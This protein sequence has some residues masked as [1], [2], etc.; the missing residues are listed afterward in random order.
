MPLSEHLDRL[1]AFEPT[2]LPV[3]TL[4]LNTQPDQHGRANFEPFVRKELQA[5]GQTFPLRSPERE[6]FEQDAG[7]IRRYLRDE[8]RPSTNGVAI[9]ACAGQDGFFEAIQLDAPFP[10]NRLYVYHQPHIYELARLDDHYRR[11]AALIADTNSARI[12]VFGLRTTLAKDGVQNTK[13]SRTSVGGW[14]QARYQRHIENY[15]LHHAKEVIETL[16]RVV[17]EEEIARLVLAGD[18]VIVP[19][20]RRQLPP[21]LADKVVD[22][23]RLDIT[24]PE[25]EILRTTVEAMREQDARDDV[26]RVQ[27]L[28]DEYRSGGLAVV[29]ARDTLAALVHGQVDRLFLTASITHLDNDMQGEDWRLFASL[30]GLDQEGATP[31]FIIPDALVTRARQTGAGTFFIEDPALLAGVGGVGAILRFRL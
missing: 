11:Y 8:L 21:H 23:L 2:P 6:S 26:E 20:L 14:S 4:Y 9:F 13:V 25:H 17:R 16:D 27:G 7:R 22:V 29:G 3:L 18:E 28:L 10:K 30:S 24:T 5:R 15:H 31:D 12:F 1:A 19:V